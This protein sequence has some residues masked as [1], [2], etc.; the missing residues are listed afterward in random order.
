MRLGAFFLSLSVAATLSAGAAR[1]QNAT[2][3]NGEA[4]RSHEVATDTTAPVKQPSY[5]N[6]SDNSITLLPYGWGYKVDPSNQSTF[7]FEH[8][9]DSAIGDLFLF[10]DA[11]K[12]HG[13]SAGVDDNTWYGEIS[14]RLSLGKTLNKDL[15][16]SL[17]GKS[18]FE[19]KDVLIAAQYERGEDSDAAEAALVGI[20][21]DLD[22]REAGLL[23][24]LG[25]FKYI[26]LN[27]Y[28]RDD[29]ATNAQHGFRDAQITMVAARPFTIGSARFLVD[30][31]F[32][33]ILGI[34]SEQWSYHINP[35]ITLDVGNIWGNPD[36]FYA[37][38][39]LDFWWNKYQIADSSAFHTNQQALS[40]IF[41]YHL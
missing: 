27:L 39:E 2:V 41:K 12:Y 1:A 33:W 30:G 4:A 24:P 10:I 37:G 15:S 21:F 13:S 20:G 29:L 11:T 19:V 35:Q 18:L 3:A 36:K 28:A 17:F 22:V 5:F 14:P 8:V 38:V 26:Q 6:W 23:G 9:H 25:K 40:L 31:Y 34:G 16:F 7:T 32:D